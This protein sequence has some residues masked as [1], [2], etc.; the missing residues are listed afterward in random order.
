M[1]KRERTGPSRWNLPADPCPGGSCH[2]CSV[3]G[4]HL[5]ERGPV[6]SGCQA[7]AQTLKVTTRD[8]QV[9]SGGW[10]EGMARDRQLLVPRAS[11]TREDVIACELLPLN[12]ATAV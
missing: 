4:A 11:Y 2:H 3:C 1:S 12:A 5:R 7:Q 10:V 6:C 8:L 9:R